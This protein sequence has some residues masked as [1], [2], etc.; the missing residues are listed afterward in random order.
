M[1]RAAPRRA[2]AR[3]SVISK[4]LSSPGVEK[5]VGKDFGWQELDDSESSPILQGMASLC[6]FL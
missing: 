5:I 1:L 2:T 6:S 4:R 3:D